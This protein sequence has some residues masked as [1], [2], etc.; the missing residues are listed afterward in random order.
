LDK[1]TTIRISLFAI[2][3]FWMQQAFA[4]SVQ[5]MVSELEPVGSSTRGQLTVKNDSAGTITLEASSWHSAMAKNGTESLSPADD[6]ILLF[7]PTAVVGPGKTQVIQ[8]QYIGDPELGISKFYRVRVEQLPVKL[9]SSSEG[10]AV[11]FQF[12]TILNVVPRQSKTQ[13]SVKAI[14]PLDKPGVYE[15]EMQNSGTRYASLFE[16]SW[17]IKSPGGNISLSARQ[18]KE[19]VSGNYV[20]PQSTRSIVFTPPD[21]V[22]LNNA[23]LIISS[24]D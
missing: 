3:F 2:L 22:S 12:D 23:S 24:N 11:A 18:I 21:G 19:S 6:D 20:L 7:P 4:V 16:S 15:I 8:I 1:F 14:K 9:N 5:P 10:V 13:L 17:V